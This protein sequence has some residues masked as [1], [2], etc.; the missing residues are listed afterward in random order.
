MSRATPSNVLDTLLTKHPREIGETY[1]EH[2]G[3]ALYI[4]M[5]MLGAGIACLV[6]AVLPGLCVRTASHAVEDIQ[7]LM[8]KRTASATNHEQVA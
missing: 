3:H 2:A 5:R 7:A 6:H 4:G 8:T 1:G